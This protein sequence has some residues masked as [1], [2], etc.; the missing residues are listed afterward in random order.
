MSARAV[1]KLLH[2]VGWYWQAVMIS[3]GNHCMHN[4][5]YIATL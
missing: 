1:L 3:A 4:W 2:V 5:L